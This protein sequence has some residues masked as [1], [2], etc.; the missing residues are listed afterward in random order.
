LG[1]VFVFYDAGRAHELAVLAGEPGNTE[2]R[3]VGAGLD[4]FPGKLVTG[5]LT[6]ADPLANGPNTRRGSS[7][8]LFIVRGSF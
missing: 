7:R 4:L 6:W 1:D 5:T 3:S 2:L 8:F